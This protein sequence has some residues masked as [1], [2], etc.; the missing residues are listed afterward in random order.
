MNCSAIFEDVNRLVVAARIDE[1]V[2]EAEPDFQRIRRPLQRFAGA[3]DRRLP[4]RRLARTLLRLL[5]R[6]DGA[7]AGQQA[8]YGSESPQNHDVEAPHW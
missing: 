8:Q 7:D 1:Q 5:V 2:R 6:T 3:D 4:C